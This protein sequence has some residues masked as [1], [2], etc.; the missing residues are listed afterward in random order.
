MAK[1]ENE[2]M[3]ACQDGEQMSE[4]EIDYNVMGS[5]PASD[6]PSWTLGVRPR[7]TCREEFEG[8]KPSP[9]DPSH[10]NEPEE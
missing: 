9:H 7:K 8:E 6:P 1:Q 10:Q 3:E 5:F 2:Q 4:A